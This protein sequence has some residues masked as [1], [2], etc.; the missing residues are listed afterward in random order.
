[1]GTNG[2]CFAVLKDD[3]PEKAVA[4]EGSCC[5]FRLLRAGRFLGTELIQQAGGFSD[6]QD[7]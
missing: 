7:L 5:S 1:M 4:E 6:G 2:K 3:L